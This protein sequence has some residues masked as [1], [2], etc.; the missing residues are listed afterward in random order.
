MPSDEADTQVKVEPG[1]CLLSLACR[2]GVPV[3]R[4]I[5]HPDNAELMRTRGHQASHLVPGDVVTIPPLQRKVEDG[6]TEQRHRFRK[7]V[8]NAVLRIH[9]SEMGQPRA[10]ESYVVLDEQGRKLKEF[11]EQEKTTDDQGLVTCEIP[12][13]AER[14]T[15][16]IG[17]FQ[18]EY[19]IHLG[20]IDPIDTV[21]GVH[22]RLQ[23]LGYY[24]DDLYT[25][26]DEGSRLAA[27]EYLEAQGVEEPDVSEP[28]DQKLKDALLGGSSA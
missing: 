17:E 27:S 19:E 23:N 20:H 2:S 7:T 15:V 8:P 12:A 28:N 26:F 9:L 10:Q 24:D 11:E 5:D 18:D 16:V 3:Q 1:D 6:A 13:D 22:G 25:D 14:V 21:S 4:I